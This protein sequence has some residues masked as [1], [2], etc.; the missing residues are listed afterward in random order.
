[1]GTFSI[2]EDFPSPKRFEKLLCRLERGDLLEIDI[3][4]SSFNK[5]KLK[6]LR[7]LPLKYF[8]LYFN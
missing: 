8:S 6:F 4:I 1:M 5:E 7:T 2:S 3:S